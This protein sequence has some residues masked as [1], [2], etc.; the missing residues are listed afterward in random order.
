M[1]T[2]RPNGRYYI[3]RKVPGIG[4]VYRS[5][6]TDRKRLATKREDMILALAHQGRQ[7]VVR[8]WLD[9]DVTLG[10]LQEA[11]ETGVVHELTVKLRQGDSTLA[12]ACDAA[13]KHK[14][15]DVAASTHER[16]STGLDHFQAFV[17]GE[18]SVRKALTDHM[19][20]EFKAYRLEEGAAEQ[21][22]NNDLGAVSILCTYAMKQSWIEERPEIN[23]FDYNARIRW[24]DADDVTTYMATLRPAFRPKMQLLVGTGMRL[25]ESEGLRVCD[26]RFGNGDSRAMI[27]DSKTSTGV[28]TVFVPE[29]A[30]EAVEEHI[31][32]HDL[33]GT[34]PVFFIERRTVQA[35]HT[36]AC[37][38]AGI[39]DYTIHD[40]RHTAAVHLARAGMPLHLLQQQL[41]HKNIEMTMK[42][43][44]FHPDYSD[45][46]GYF[47]RVGTRL[48]LVDE[49][50]DTP[51][52]RVRKAAD[53][54]GLEPD[55]LAALVEAAGAAA[56][57]RTNNTPSEGSPEEASREVA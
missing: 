32:E 31:R 20:Q 13:L 12:D 19:I 44:R 28:R 15:P 54:L 45:V 43:S 49:E 38:L 22:V 47:E 48:G 29:W 10:G 6:R 52:E 46:A 41:G 4:K 21:T 51:E 14:K 8:A 3:Q 23:R 25:G 17:G 36:R 56:N 16:Y 26:L 1:P 42:Y 34:D 37:K 2:E 30:A 50:P 35:E 33:S 39:P 9:G 24:L 53:L 27:E 55:R 57:N 5:L 7:A 18:A 11:Y 40:H